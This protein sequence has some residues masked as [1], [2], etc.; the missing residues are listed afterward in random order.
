MERR[1]T[2]TE[3]PEK[4]TMD[5]SKLQNGSDIRG[6]ALATENG[7]EVNLTPEAVERIG[8]AFAEE[9]K[10]RIGKDCPRISVGRD[11]RVTGELLSEALIR[12]ICSAG[13][14][15]AYFGLA[16][17]PCMFM[18]TVDPDEPFDGAVMVTASHLPMNRNGLKFFTK[19]GGFEKSDIKSLLTSAAELEPKPGKAGSC[20][21]LDYLRAGGGL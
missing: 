19:D 13:A 16:S 9:M 17:T 14:N 18:S 15:A 4:K 3:G 20:V 2:G 8:S 7:P 11:S 10:K 5:Y 21:R 6:I 1:I 12:G